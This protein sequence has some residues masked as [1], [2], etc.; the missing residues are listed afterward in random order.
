MLRITQQRIE[1]MSEIQSLARGLAILDL[2]AQADH[3]L[4]ITEIAQA[5]SI[6]KSSA[7]RMV[8]TLVNHDYV[9]P[10]GQTRRYRLG[11]RLHQIGWQ[12]VNRMP[13]REK[14]HPYLEQL[15]Q[16]TGECAHTAVYSQG[17]A[18]VIDDVEART[19]LRVSGGT[20]RLI[21]LHCTAIG[22]SLLAFGD[23][24]LP[25]EL[26]HYMPATITNAD[27]LH[28]HLA[29]IRSQGYALDDEEHEP[30]VRCLAAPVFDYLG[31][32]I[33]SIGISGPTVRITP[34]RIPALAEHVIRAAYALSL[35]LGYQ[36]DEAHVARMARYNPGSTRR[37]K[38]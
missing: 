26:T 24:T 2:F 29:R 15:V 5:L 16:Q 30:G 10:D 1:I 35:D 13:L 31:A 21:P 34:E 28:T 19:S 20:G 32:V 9:Q 37:K 6:D 14:A 8:R 36:P 7:S 27:A 38:A 4:S 22:K 17:K 18:L 25:T 23:M 12:L 3:S 33:S 11:K